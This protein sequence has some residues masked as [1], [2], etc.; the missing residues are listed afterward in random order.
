M[1][2]DLTDGMV[3]KTSSGDLTF[4]NE[5]GSWYVDSQGSKAMIIGPD[6]GATNG[7][8]H[9]IDTVLLPAPDATTAASTAAPQL[10]I[11]GLAQSVPSLSTLVTAVIK[12]GLVDTLNSAGPFTV[13]APNNAAF[14]KIGSAA[15]NDILAN[16]AQLTKILMLHVVAGKVMS[17]DLT[18]GMVAKTSSG[19]LTFTNEGGSWYVD[20]QGSKAMI[21][22][23]DNGAT[24][25]VAHV[26][27]TVLL[28]APDATA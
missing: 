13:F 22:G 1:S 25:G 23:P 20:S 21:I 9:V 7:V 26:I 15:L 6:N 2:G 16:K 8:A 28:P 5:G 4:T 11:V 3:A 24:N 14:A 19:D 18:D 17:G 27:D 12:A 10:T